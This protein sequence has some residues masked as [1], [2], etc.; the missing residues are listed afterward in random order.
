MFKLKI[1]LVL[2]LFF[3]ACHSHKMV[4]DKHDSMTEITPPNGVELE[5]NLFY[6]Q[7]EISNLHWLEYLYW[8][9]KIYGKN[10]EQY[11]DAMPDTTVWHPYDS[12]EEV[13]SKSYL[14][15]VKYR[16]NPVLGVSYEQAKAFSKWRSDRAMEYMLISNGFID[17]IEDQNQENYFTTARFLNGEIKSKKALTEL[18][19]YIEFRLPTE[20]EWRMALKHNEEIRAS[21]TKSDRKELE[22]CF[23]NREPIVAKH[24]ICLG[25]SQSVR[26][27]NWVTAPCSE[28]LGLIFNLQG[29]AREWIQSGETVGGG[30]GDLLRTIQTKDVYEEIV[31]A[32]EFTGFRCVSSWIPIAQG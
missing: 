23:Q 5:P 11:S 19:H 4:I 6:D 7:T 12:C 20:S 21:A 16:M 2:I 1:A 14:R 9:N 13:Y 10:S 31:E 15:H 26:P 22:K 27:T 3:A 17:R 32:T 28:K 24:Y 30:W 25:D 29:N 8:I 18:T